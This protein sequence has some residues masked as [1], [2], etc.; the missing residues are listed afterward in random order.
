LTT[1]RGLLRLSLA[2][3][4]FR[5]QLQFDPT[6]VIV[7]IGIGAELGSEQIL[8][9]GGILTVVAGCCSRGSHTRYHSVAEGPGAAS[10][11]DI[12]DM[13]QGAPGCFP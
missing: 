9:C 3:H 7:Y 5:C 11:G 1:G 6:T 4:W 2:S 13:F 10:S 12:H 8:P